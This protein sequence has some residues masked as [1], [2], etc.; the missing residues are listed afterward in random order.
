MPKTMPGYS[1]STHGGC[2][3]VRH[4]F[5]ERMFSRFDNAGFIMKK[6]EI[7][8]GDLKR[9]LI[10]NAP[11]EF[12]LEIL[13]RTLL[14][15]LAVM[16]VVRLLGKRMSG[17]VTLVEMA[18]LVM[19][20]AIVGSPIQIPDRGILTALVILVAAMG[21]QY[22][23]NKVA[24]RYPAFEQLTQGRTTLLV[25][26]GIIQR[27]HMQRERV[28]IQQLFALLRSH[29]IRHL[30]G[31]KRVY[32]GFV[33]LGQVKRVYF[34]AGGFFSLVRQE[35]AQ[36]GL[37]LIPTWDTDFV[38]EQELAD[39]IEVCRQCGHRRGGGKCSNCG[40]DTWERAL[41]GRGR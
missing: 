21:I 35:Q 14:V 3:A 27:E 2:H 4:S 23:M 17:Q 19:L 40:N 31:V 5:F 15:Y 16:I 24:Y 30:G 38:F 12:L 26:D 28:S 8:L 11:P 22:V 37:S 41:R 20:G 25:K 39:D 29:E 36:P 9:I 33:D 6:E 32:R 7:Y 18:L 1:Y 34:E 13:L 10:G